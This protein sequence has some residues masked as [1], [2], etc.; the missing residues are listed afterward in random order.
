VGRTE[1]LGYIWDGL[2]GVTDGLEVMMG[3]VMIDINGAALPNL[4][5]VF[6]VG[7]CPCTDFVT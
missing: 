6:G 5:L 2:E 4:P 3:L 1:T 7:Y